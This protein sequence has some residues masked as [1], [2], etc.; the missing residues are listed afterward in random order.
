LFATWIYVDT[1]KEAAVLKKQIS[2]PALN[3]VIKMRRLGGKESTGGA[4]AIY[5]RGSGKIYE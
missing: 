5:F 2:K 1:G 4:K 3:F